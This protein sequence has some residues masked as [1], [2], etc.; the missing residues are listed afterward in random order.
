MTERPELFAA[1]VPEVPGTDLVRWDYGRH[2]AQMGTISNPEHF[3]FLLAGS[4]LHRLVPGTCYPATLVT[5]ALNDERMHAWNAL[6]FAA[7][8]QHAQGCAVPVL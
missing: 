4:P 7:A 8:L 5:T 3:A 6:K 1:A 2:R